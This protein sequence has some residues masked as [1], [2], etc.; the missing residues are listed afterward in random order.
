MKI[1]GLV[2]SLLRLDK[3][4][5]ASRK[6]RVVHDQPLYLPVVEMRALSLCVGAETVSIACELPVS[7]W[8]HEGAQNDQLII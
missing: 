7:P 6:T 8:F 5:R 3:C 4:D 2:K 1:K